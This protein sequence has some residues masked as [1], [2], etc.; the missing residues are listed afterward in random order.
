[1]KIENIAFSQPLVESYFSK[2][3]PQA[4]NLADIVNIIDSTSYKSHVV[5]KCMVLVAEHLLGFG[6]EGVIQ[7]LLRVLVVTD[8]LSTVEEHSLRLLY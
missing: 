1:M 6:Q 7:L 5:G 8:S 4:K 3:D 2:N